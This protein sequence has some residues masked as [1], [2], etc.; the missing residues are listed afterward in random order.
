MTE[1]AWNEGM[2][3][4]AKE[5]DDGHRKIIYL[6]S[7][8]I[9]NLAT[10]TTEAEVELSFAELESCIQE[11]FA[12]KESLL[13]AMDYKEFSRYKKSHQ[14]FID[15]VLLL[16]QQWLAEPSTE[17]KETL[18]DNLQQW[19]LEHTLTEDTDVASALHCHQKLQ[20]YQAQK[21][22]KNPFLRHLSK[23]LS[24]H[25][26]ISQ[27]VFITTFF[28]IGVALAL[29]FFLLKDD[30]QR[31]QNMSLLYGL[32]TV[33]G[34]VNTLSHSLQAERG[35]SSGYI[36]SDFNK[37]SSA[38]RQRRVITDE[39]IMNFFSSLE[40]ISDEKVKK[41][42]IYYVKNTRRTIE[43]LRENRK[44]ID[45]SLFTSSQSNQAY[46]RLIGQ[47]LSI[48]GNLIHVDL[49]SQ[50][51][52]E[53]S[54]INAILLF[55]EYTGQI[56]A[57]GM[58]LFESDY[59]NI[60][61]PIE[62][63]GYKDNVEYRNLILVM[64]KQLNVLRSFGYLAN[65]QQKNICA[66]Y[67]DESQ[68][69]QLINQY[70]DHVI[71]SH[72]PEIRSGHWFELMSNEIDSVKLIADKL[73]D[74]F[75]T[76][77]QRE[78]QTIEN[79]FFWIF[80]IL[81]SFLFAAILFA[82]VLNYSIISPVRKLT[83][84]LNDMS[85]G[86]KNIQFKNVISKDEIAEMQLAYE[87]LRRKLI[88]ADVYK[89]TVNYQKKEIQYR[90]SQ[91]DHFQHLALTDALTGAVNRHHFNDILDREIRNVNQCEQ[92][93]SIMLLD[94]DHFKKINDSYGH[95]IGDEVLVM[96]YGTCKSAARVGDVIARIGGEEFV[97]VMP[98]TRLAN[99]QQ[100]AERLRKKVEELEIAVDN[101]KVSVTVSIGV[102]QWQEELFINAQAFVAH[103]DKSLY[104]AKNSGRNKVI[105]A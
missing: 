58:D 19:L 82:L 70:I 3:V 11:H 18:V 20:E 77:I 66:D 29:C 55:K 32:N 44:N 99:A 93:L 23:K 12:R 48:S 64:G 96:F 46:T 86:Q 67:C 105:A 43:E 95:R 81:V 39:K 40:L 35:L 103:A 73:I 79:S 104:Q 26:T 91:Q 49:D 97:I 31:F 89:A 68:Q 4:D 51:R 45:N 78:A 28:P 56:R 7:Q 25:I 22:S 62:S 54:A 71:S 42:I 36:N 69:L 15:K 92:P 63:K 38:L 24:K 57:A 90:K 52:N 9:D 87:K 72:Q 101:V 85:S 74:D 6:L 37:Y 34:Q 53:L 8:L 60:Y 47:L 1:L 41:S 102:S 83:Y 14:D 61:N 100:C 30:Y 33:I 16:K 27:R 80:L 2:N 13:N 98:N 17:V 84:A 76:R 21:K 59:K 88:Q 94:I 65:R 50:L 10:Q 5:I 75:S